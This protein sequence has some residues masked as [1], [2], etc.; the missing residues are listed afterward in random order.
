VMVKHYTLKAAYCD[1][2]RKHKLNY[3]NNKK[4]VFVKL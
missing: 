4:S 1:H 3:Y 2:N